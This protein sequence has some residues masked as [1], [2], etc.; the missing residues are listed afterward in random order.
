MTTVPV[1]AVHPVTT[2]L[3]VLAD[4]CGR[5]T[6]LGSVLARRSAEPVEVPAR[7]RGRGPVVLVGGFGTTDH[8]LRVLRGW[9]ERL[10]Y[11]VTV[12]TTGIGTGCGGRSVERLRRVIDAAD[13]GAG[14]GVVAHSRG[15]QFARVATASGAR[16][17]SLVALGAPFDQFPLSVPAL[18]AGLLVGV[19]GSLGV[20]GLASLGCVR[21]PCCAEFRA[22]LRA[23]VPVP[24]TSVYTRGDQV[25]PWR[26]SV[27][28]AAHNVE[29]SGGHLGLLDRPDALAA[30]AAA[31]AA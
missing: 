23:P 22:A 1:D 24:F 4:A 29:V 30:V 11:R 12:H 10:G 5:V 31:L 17:R 9:L 14:V 6:E 15:A 28:D 21:G 3:T 26:S 27:D 19:A 20:P 13:E 16:V 2:A 25:V 7:W 8:G 18:A